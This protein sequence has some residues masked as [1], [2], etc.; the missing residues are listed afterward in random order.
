MKKYLSPEILVLDFSAKDVIT[1]S[2][3]TAKNDSAFK[4]FDYDDLKF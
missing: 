3:L 2:E 1:L 4:Q